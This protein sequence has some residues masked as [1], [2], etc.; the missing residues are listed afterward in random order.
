VTKCLQGRFN[1]QGY[2]ELQITILPRDWR[3]VTGQFRLCYDSRFSCF[4][5]A[6]V[7]EVNDENN[8]SGFHM[9]EYFDEREALR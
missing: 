8:L 3:A 9:F 6:S 7:P 5:F 4:G 1:G 2:L